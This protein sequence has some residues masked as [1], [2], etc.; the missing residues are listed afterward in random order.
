[1]TSRGIRSFALI[2]NAFVMVV[3]CERPV[4]DTELPGLYVM[5]EGRAADTLWLRR[6]GRFVRRF[7]PNIGG[8]AVASIDS[9]VWQMVRASDRPPELVVRGIT[10]WWETEM[11]PAGTSR[12]PVQRTVWGAPVERAGGGRPS[13]AVDYDLGWAYVRVQP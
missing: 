11:W 9:G 3:A 6:D 7:V 8:G 5:N 1:M 12:P 2:L 4:S 10:P 13:L